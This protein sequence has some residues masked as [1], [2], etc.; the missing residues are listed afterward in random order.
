MRRLVLLTTLLLAGF[1][2]DACSAQRHD[3][4]TLQYL[5]ANTNPVIEPADTDPRPL[6]FS[7]SQQPAWLKPL[8]HDLPAARRK[9]VVAESALVLKR[10]DRPSHLAVIWNRGSDLRLFQLFVLKPR[11]GKIPYSA[12]LIGD[13]REEY[14]HIVEPSGLDIHGDGV[15]T[16]FVDVGSGG[17][18]AE[19]YGVSVLK[20]GERVEDITPKT[21]RPILVADLDGDGSFE[22]VGSDDRWANLVRSC[23]QCGPHIPVVNRWDG[24]RYVPA[25][26]DF[27]DYYKA[28][29]ALLG[30]AHSIEVF[31]DYSADS[32]LLDAQMARPEA[33][34]ETLAEL[35]QTVAGHGKW[36][37]LGYQIAD[38]I[39]RV[40][41]E[42]D[43][44]Q[45]CPLLGAKAPVRPLFGDVKRRKII[46]GR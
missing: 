40:V 3:P 2:H 9:G 39:E 33:A 8:L 31:I 16:V 45:P 14:L 36:E 25:C 34:R 44:S 20:L 17:S 10:A 12:H 6:A 13:I 29:Q 1:G 41:A 27:P 46:E 21:A 23:G 22:I 18:G 37:D 30:E 43:F 26:R 11:E 7:P 15:P 4:K 42:A 35:R 38:S 32:A 28:R 19:G 24:R 5:G